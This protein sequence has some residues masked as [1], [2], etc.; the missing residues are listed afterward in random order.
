[1]SSP[2]IRVLIIDDSAVVRRAVTDALAHDPEIEVVGTAIDP[3][4]ARDKIV[5]LKPDVLTLDI[6]MP[7]M[8]GLTFLK[9]IME[10]RPLPVIIMSSLTK[11]GSQHAMEALRLGAVDV[12]G[13]PGGSYSFGDLGPQLISK[14]KAAAQ[15][16]LRRPV[17]TRAP[18]AAPPPPPANP[19]PA[20]AGAETPAGAGEVATP[21]SAASPSSLSSASSTSSKLPLP[22]PKVRPRLVVAPKALPPKLKKLGSA[23]HHDPRRI[24]L[25]G[26]STG[27]TEALREVLQH[28]PGDLPPIAIV[29]HIPAHFSK[30]FADRLNTS[31]AMEIREAV[32]GVRLIPGVALIAPGNFHMMLQW[33][34]D[35]YRV[36]VADGPMVWHQ[37]PAV[38]VLFKS[39]LDCAGHHA[40]AGVLTGM[41]KD[42]AEGLLRL[43]ERGALTFAQDEATC[44]VYGMPRVAWEMGGAQ[45]QLPIE[46]VAEHII[47]LATQPTPPP[48]LN[49][50]AYGTAHPHV[51]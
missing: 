9:I 48:V 35:S 27:G 45:C 7:R 19:S 16:R 15:A 51:V 21:P 24:I 47:Q 6:E 44:V 30:A 14:I 13:K 42:G 3:Y 32:D 11:N 36:R 22:P 49:V 40:I 2:R 41:G 46:R 38:D 10:E 34:G 17:P 5:Q 20:P 4:L 12:L 37:R 25:L 18:F 50:P 23:Y 29:Q 31:C 1:M 28:L 43:R 39:A 33:A 26:A 8:D